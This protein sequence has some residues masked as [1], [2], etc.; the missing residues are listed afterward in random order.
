MTKHDDERVLSSF[1]VGHYRLDNTTAS[2]NP[3]AAIAPNPSV[4]GVIA[5][6]IVLYII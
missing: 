2:P 3:N 1:Y 4:D 5:I 6:P